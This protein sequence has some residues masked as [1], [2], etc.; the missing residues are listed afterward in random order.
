MD[1]PVFPDRRMFRLH[2]ADV[3]PNAPGAPL[4]PVG[5]LISVNREQLWVGSLQEQLDGFRIFAHVSFHSST[6]YRQLAYQLIDIAGA[7]VS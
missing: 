3:D 6:L 2:D 5:S 1:I 7:I 4:P